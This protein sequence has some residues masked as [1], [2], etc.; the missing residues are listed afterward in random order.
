MRYNFHAAGMDYV[1]VTSDLMLNGD[2]SRTC[3]NITVNDDDTLE[4]VE[5]FLVMLT[6]QDPRVEVDRDQAVVEIRDNDGT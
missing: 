3:L 4:P 6:E 2:T 5:E 1:S